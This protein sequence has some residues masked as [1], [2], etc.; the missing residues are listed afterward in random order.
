MTSREGRLWGSGRMWGTTSAPAGL[1]FIRRAELKRRVDQYVRTLLMLE[2]A[3]PTVASIDMWS[4]HADYAF[5]MMVYYSIVDFYF[6]LT[7][8]AFKP[9]LDPLLT[10]EF[11]CYFMDGLFNVV[12]DVLRHRV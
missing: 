2:H 7:L 12:D 4:E 6:S 11:G 1:W 9:P 8:C 5:R 3:A 10:L